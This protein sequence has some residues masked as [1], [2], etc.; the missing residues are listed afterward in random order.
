MTY[1]N[2]ICQSLSTFQLGLLMLNRMWYFKV[3]LGIAAGFI[4][5]SQRECPLWSKAYQD[6]YQFLLR[7]CGS[8]NHGWGI[9][10]QQSTVDQGQ[11]NDQ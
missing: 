10:N 6:A 7:K 9:D 11:I 2:I 5:L 3:T 4:K 1:R 8:S